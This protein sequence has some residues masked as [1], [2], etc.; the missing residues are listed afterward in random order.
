MKKTAFVTGATSGFGK[1]IAKKFAEAGYKVIINGRRADRLQSLAEEL[2]QKYLAPVHIAS[3]D[4]RD[5]DAVFKAVEAF[6]SEFQY[7]DVLVNNA[8]LALGRDYFEDARIEDWETMIDTNVK[9]LL[10]VTRAVL[11]KMV[12][13]SSGHI[14]NIGSVA[15]KEVYEK[16]N[17]YCGTKHAVTAL[18]E[19]MRIDLLKNK[20]K[21]TAI[22]PGAAN[23]EFSAVRFKGNMELAESVYKGYEPLKAEDIADIVLYC[24]SLPERVVINDLVVTA[25]A[26]ANSFYFLREE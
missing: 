19:A 11:P 21:V 10:Y 23:T 17:V 16:G 14:I 7:V 4:V 22:H 13:R 3:F 5:K 12:E 6:P 20:I 1:A 18:S 8:G 24:V 26:Q 25:L 15:G 9:G 2:T